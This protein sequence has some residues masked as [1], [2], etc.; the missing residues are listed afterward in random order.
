MGLLV[1]AFGRLCWDADKHSASRFPRARLPRQ[2]DDDFSF[3][4]AWT[5]TGH[6]PFSE[7]VS[8][9]DLKANLR[10]VE[11]ALKSGRNAY[12]SQ[13]KGQFSR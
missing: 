11:D 10:P 7:V 2:V 8:A 4:S 5:C 6:R 12:S 9:Y 13:V 3:Q 1:A